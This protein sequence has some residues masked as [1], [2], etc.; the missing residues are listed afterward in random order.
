MCFPST[1]YK[2]LKKKFSCNKNRCFE[3]T[4]DNKLLLVIVHNFGTVKLVTW[5]KNIHID[6]KLTEGVG[7]QSP[8]GNMVMGK[9]EIG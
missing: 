5:E 9:N 1:Y 8:E 4:I 2:S 3:V 6:K 7:L